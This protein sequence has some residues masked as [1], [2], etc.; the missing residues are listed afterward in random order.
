MHTP[1]SYFEGELDLDDIGIPKGLI[2]KEIDRELNFDNLYLTAPEGTVVVSPTDGI[3]KF[4]NYVFEGPSLDIVNNATPE[5]VE[6][7]VTRSLTIEVESGKNLFVQGFFT[8]R[9]FKTGEKIKR[10]DT[11][12]TIGYSYF[13]FSQPSLQIGMSINTKSADPMT[14]FGI[15]TTF[16]PPNMRIIET[17]TKKEAIAD[18]QLLIGSLKEGYPGMYDYL[19]PQEIDLFIQQIIDNLPEEIPAIAFEGIIVSILAKIHDSHIGLKGTNLNRREERYF[20]SVAFGVLNDS[21]IL[22]GTQEKYLDYFGR[23]I[24]EVDGIPADSMIRILHSYITIYD[25]YVESLPQSQALTA[26]YQSYFNYHP[27]ASPNG[28]VKLKFSDGEEIAFQGIKL[29]TGERPKYLPDMKAHDAINETLSLEKLNSTTAYMGIHSFE[30]NEMEMEKVETFVKALADSSCPYLIIDVRN[31]RGG[32]EDVVTKIFSYLVN[33]PFHH[34][35]YEKVNTVEAFSFFEYSM[36]YGPG[37]P[38][39]FAEKDYVRVRGKEGFY[40]MMNTMHEPDSHINYTGKVYLLTNEYSS[41]ASS[42]LAGY[43][44]KYRRGVI[45]GRETGSTYHQ[46]NAMKFIDLRL[47]NSETDIRFPLVKTVFDTIVNADFPYGR[48][49]I[50]HYIVPLTLEELTLQNGDTIL[51]Y[52]LNLIDKGIYFPEEPKRFTLKNILLLSAGIVLAGLGIV[53]IIRRR[54]DRTR[55]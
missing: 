47:P 17:L 38:G 27:N 9:E 36:N 53:L 32:S 25:G 11:L 31:N 7:Y 49:V 42:N 44:K 54:N 1:Q 6:K 22:I 26:T 8:D 2:P 28:E 18:I 23:R 29:K 51:N 19:T 35:L 50:P 52:T 55:V 10:G 40:K 48:G 14:P 43:I 13:Y 20:P 33:Q 16:R 45:V 46:M 4:A 21:L 3:I 41:S 39:I 5:F 12:G 37:M 30:L 34:T 15:P 24:V